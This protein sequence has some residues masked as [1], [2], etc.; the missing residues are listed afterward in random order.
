MMDGS[1]R[2]LRNSID[3]DVK[4]APATRNYGEIISADSYSASLVA[5]TRA[6]PSG[7]GAIAGRQSPHD[8]DDHDGGP[9][10]LRGRSLGKPDNLTF[11]GPVVD[12]RHRPRAPRLDRNVAAST[13]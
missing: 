12:H 6:L 5:P 11:Q 3:L 7:I 1:V 10:R 8:G 2:F 9:G 13:S 4:R